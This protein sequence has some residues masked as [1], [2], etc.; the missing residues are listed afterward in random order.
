MTH[1][2]IR[3]IREEHA[4]LAAMLRSMLLLL[5]QHKRAG[6]PPDF[7]ILRAMLFYVD[8]FPE[9]R[10][11]RK[12][13][14]LLFPMLRARTPMSRDLLDHLD[15]EH[16][17]GERRIRNVEH[18]LLGYE[19]LGEPRRAAFEQVLG[20]YVNF[21]L[22]H[23][24]VEERELLPLAEKVLTSDD[25]SVFDRAFAANR[26]PFAGHAPEV[27]YQAFY[28]RIVNAVPEPI[29]LGP[30][31]TQGRAARSDDS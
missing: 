1:E 30:A 27:D 16:A 19:M 9:K 28:T 7:S 18:A 29:G 15:A 10:H 6:T 22:A 14:E 8:E 26:D 31:L 5:D 17:S 11:H 25:W 23:M 3:I 12:E 4:A 13:S 24:A 21:Y 2:A 20:E